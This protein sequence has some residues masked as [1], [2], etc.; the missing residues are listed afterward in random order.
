MSNIYLIFTFYNWISS[1]LHYCLFKN[2]LKII[3]LFIL[4]VIELYFPCIVSVS[5]SLR[6][7]SIATQNNNIIT[8]KIVYNDTD[9]I[10]KITDISHLYVVRTNVNFL[11]NVLSRDYRMLVVQT[12]TS[13]TF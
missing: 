13:C 4:F 1:V 11:I 9:G 6:T 7:L 10:I 5:I 2:G 3:F 8:V 12:H